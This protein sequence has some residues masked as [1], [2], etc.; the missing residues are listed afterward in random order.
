MDGAVPVIKTAVTGASESPP[1]AVTAAA[2]GARAPEA[3][4]P[5]AGPGAA[6]REGGAAA[7]SDATAR[8]SVVFPHTAMS[9]TAPANGGGVAHSAAPFSSAASAAVTPARAK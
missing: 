3:V 6:A 9:S 7:A 4:A 8:A 5:A 1:D 2:D